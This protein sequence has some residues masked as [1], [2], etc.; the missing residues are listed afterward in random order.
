MPTFKIVPLTDTAARDATSSTNTDGLPDDFRLIPI[1]DTQTAVRLSLHA[2][3]SLSLSLA[4]VLLMPDAWQ[5]TTIVDLVER[6]IPAELGI[7]SSQIQVLTPK[8]AGSLGSRNL[9]ELLQMRLNPPA[10]H[11]GELKK[12][13]YTFRVGDRVMQLV[14][15]YTKGVYNGETGCVSYVGPP[16][17]PSASSRTR[18]AADLAAKAGSELEVSFDRLE[19]V[20]FE[21]KELEKLAP[22]YAIT[23][24]KSQG[25][26]FPVVVMPIHMEHRFMLQRNLLYTAVTRARRLV[27]VVGTRSAIELAIARASSEGSGRLTGL[28]YQLERAWH[29]RSHSAQQR[30]PV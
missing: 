18:A 16:R 26:E 4:I 14:N 27:V 20:T 3:L 21:A 12:Y 25:S 15:D 30:Y 28:R 10:K 7:P 6:R 2:N 9:N 22:A 11:K 5:V 29:A 1:E 19:N 17:T 13:G 23:I 8:A 24:H